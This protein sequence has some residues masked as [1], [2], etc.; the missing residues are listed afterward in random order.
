M[1]LQTV[2][3]CPLRPDSVNNSNN[4][5]YT[6]ILFFQTKLLLLELLNKSVV[7]YEDKN[8][9][10]S[11]LVCSMLHY[12]YEAQLFFFWQE[13]VGL[14]TLKCSWSPTITISLI[15]K[16]NLRSPQRQTIKT[17]SLGGGNF[18]KRQNNSQDE[19]G[20][21][22]FQNTFLKMKFIYS[23]NIQPLL[24]RIHWGYKVPDFSF[25]LTA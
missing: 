14:E 24:H 20:Q 17:T 16:I 23:G 15:K 9:F 1:S 5:T 21:I 25:I 2:L 11:T 10:R 12:M 7:L 8:S 18:Q 22:V 19:V 4:L 6:S 13:Q 3:E